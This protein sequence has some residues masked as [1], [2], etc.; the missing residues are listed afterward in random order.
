MKWKWNEHEMKWK[1]VENDMKWIEMKEWMNGWMN[2]WMNEWM[3]ESINQWSLP[4]SSS[5]NPPNVTVLFRCEIKLS[6]QS[7]AP[8]PGLIFQK[9]SKHDSF[10]RFFF[11]WNRTLATVL[12]TFGQPIFQKCSDPSFLQF[13]C[14]TEL[15]LQSRVHNLS[16]TFADQGPK[17]RKQRPYFG[18]HGSRVREC[19]QGVMMW[20]TWWHDDVVAM[21]VRMRAMTIVHNLEVFKLNFLW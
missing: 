2:K 5:N 17:P 14:D 8:F 15:S 7:R 6:L 9:R 13:L 20:L 21:T 4:T 18:D 16:T 1:W 11:M 10:L 3:N 12:C 19:F